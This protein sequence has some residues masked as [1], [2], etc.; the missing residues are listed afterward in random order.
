VS[1][2]HETHGRGQPLLVLSGYGVRSSALRPVVAPLSEHFTCLTFDYP[3][4][5]GRLPFSP[6]TIPAMAAAAVAVLDR[7][8]HP[9]ADVLGISLGGMVAQEMAIR[10][11]DRVRGLV[12]AATTPGGPRADVPAPWTLLAGFASMQDAFTDPQVGVG[13][14]AMLA[15]TLAAS[16][17]D[18][19]RRL[20][21]I[22]ADTLIVHG[23]RDVLVP[24]A[25]AH[26]LHRGIP[27]STLDVV[28]GA[29]HEYFFA[30]A[31]AAA[32]RV[33]GFLEER[34]PRPAAR[35]S[36]LRRATERVDRA[37]APQ[38]A[39]LRAGYGNAVRAVEWL[40]RGPTA[41]GPSAPRAA[42]GRTTSAADR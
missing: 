37:L 38:V 29:G 11:P 25:N 6:L 31:D 14:Y 40:S 28:P 33:L 9:C 26:L 39:C 8:G 35:V 20:S 16:V 24:V 18:T 5:G 42:T 2:R 30:E 27:G 17:H 4:T 13:A 10:F 19:S 23:D 21:R 3:V 1:L 41:R 7:A 32:A 22:R 15:Q 12:L 34:D 36:G